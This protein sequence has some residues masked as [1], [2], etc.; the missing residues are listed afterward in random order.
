MRL[1]HNDMLEDDGKNEV[2]DLIFHHCFDFK[3]PNF[4]TFWRILILQVTSIGI[5]IEHTPLDLVVLILEEI[6]HIPP[7]PSN[8]EEEDLS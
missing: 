6:H 7:P 2:A 3:S 4:R 5:S 8:L 1:Q